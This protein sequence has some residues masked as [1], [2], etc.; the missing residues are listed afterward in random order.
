[1]M[2]PQQEICV[3]Q[4]DGIREFDAHASV[5]HEHTD[6]T[7]Q[8]PL[9]ISHGGYLGRSIAFAQLISTWARMSIRPHIRTVLP[10][11][12][13]DAH[14]RFVSRIHGL[15]AAYYA[16]EITAKDGRTNLR[17]ELLYAAKPRIDAMGRRQ[18]A[19]VAKGQL[20]EL[21][22]VH[23]ARCQFHS[24]TYRQTPTV[25]DLLDPQRHSSLIVSSRE[26]NALITNVLK[27]QN[28]PQSDFRLFAP[29]L[30]TQQ[31]PLGRLLHEVFRNTAEHAYLDAHISPH[32]KLHIT[33]NTSR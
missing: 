27:A 11:A 22:F 19:D 2:H 24:A 32:F 10:T 33:A 17:P 18:F 29:L 20:T 1:M 6:A 26:M 8:V 4:D 21:V 14:E 7:L 31:F 5:A 30:E 9:T 16:Q 3:L 25:V 23:H 13:R 28:L 15:T 12:S